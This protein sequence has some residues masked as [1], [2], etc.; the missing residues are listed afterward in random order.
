[1]SG[2]PK[3][4]LRNM[5]DS[6]PEAAS[7]VCTAV[8]TARRRVQDEPPISTNAQDNIAE[9]VHPPILSAQESDAMPT[10]LAAVCN[11]LTELEIMV[12]T[13]RGNKNGAD[14]KP[15]MDGKD[16]IDGT[17]GTNGQDG[18]PGRDGMTGMHI[19][20][21]GLPGYVVLHGAHTSRVKVGRWLFV[22]CLYAHFYVTMCE[23]IILC[24]HVLRLPRCLCRVW[25]HRL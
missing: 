24:T 4:T 15:G 11:R 2:R 18:A 19:V 20:H 25:T 17:N 7:R 1:M 6:T 10:T 21:E 8:S 3:R 9:G 12:A 5:H 14:G 16:G 23:R 22:S 13:L